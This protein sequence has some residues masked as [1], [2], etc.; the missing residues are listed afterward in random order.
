VLIE[1]LELEV[2]QTDRHDEVERD[3]AENDIARDGRAGS[4]GREGNR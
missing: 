4:S 1:E 2:F 3:C